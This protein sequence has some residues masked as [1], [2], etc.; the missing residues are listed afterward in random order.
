MEICTLFL[1]D[2]NCK[3]NENLEEFYGYQ[4]KWKA[5]KIESVWKKHR[6]IIDFKI[7]DFCYQTKLFLTKIK[8]L[9][10]ISMAPF[11]E[12]LECGNIAIY[13]LCIVFYGNLYCSEIYINLH[14]KWC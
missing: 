5:L 9:P 1:F 2:F 8:C 14:I 3:I 11:R 10:K 13:A 7:D 4:L 6:Q 12:E